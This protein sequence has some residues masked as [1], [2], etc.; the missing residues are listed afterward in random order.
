MVSIWEHLIE[1]ERGRAET[2]TLLRRGMDERQRQIGVSTGS[3]PTDSK[4]AEE[5]ILLRSQSHSMLQGKGNVWYS[6]VKRNVVSVPHD[7]DHPKYAVQRIPGPEIP[8]P[9]LKESV[10]QISKQPPL[11]GASQGIPSN[12]LKATE[13]NLVQYMVRDSYVKLINSDLPLEHFLSADDKKKFEYLESFLRHDPSYKIIKPA[14]L[15]RQD[16]SKFEMDDN[17][18]VAKLRQ[19]VEDVEN[20]LSNLID[21]SKRYESEQIQK[22][23]PSYE[24]LVKSPPEA[25]RK[26]RKSPER[27]SNKSP[28]INPD[29]QPKKRKLDPLWSYNNQVGHQ[30]SGAVE[31]TPEQKPLRESRCDQVIIIGAHEDEEFSDNDEKHVRNRKQMEDFYMSGE[32]PPAVL[33][34]SESLLAGQ[35]SM[36]DEWD[37]FPGTE[38][39]SPDI[40]LSTEEQQVAAKIAEILSA[41][42]DSE[43]FSQHHYEPSEAS[44]FSVPDW[45]SEVTSFTSADNVDIMPD[46]CQLLDMST[47]MKATSDLPV[48]VTEQPTGFVVEKLVDLLGSEKAI[49]KK[50]PDSSVGVVDIHEPK[51]IFPEPPLIEEMDTLERGYDVGEDEEFPPP[52]PPE[53]SVS[54]SS[55]AIETTDRSLEQRYLILSEHDISLTDT[56][57]ESNLQN[58]AE[59]NPSNFVSLLSAVPLEEPVFTTIPQDIPGSA[60]E[61]VEGAQKLSPTIV[62]SVLDETERN[63]QISPDA[64]SSAD[65]QVQ[66]AISESLLQELVMSKT[67]KNVTVFE[68][69]DSESQIAEPVPVHFQIMNKTDL[70][71]DKMQVCEAHDHS[72]KSPLTSSSF[73]KA[74]EM[75]EQMLDAKQGIEELQTLFAKDEYDTEVPKE[76]TCL[77]TVSVTTVKDEEYDAEVPKEGTCSPTVSVTTVKKPDF[78]NSDAEI[79]H[80]DG[81]LIVETCINDAHP[82]QGLKETEEKPMFREYIKEKEK[83]PVLETDSLT[84]S[85]ASDDTVEFWKMASHNVEK[86]IAVIEGAVERLTES[87]KELQLDDSNEF[88]LSDKPVSKD[89]EKF[90]EKPWEGA[91][92]KSDKPLSGIE[93][94]TTTENVKV[95]KAS[96]ESDTFCSSDGVKQPTGTHYNLPQE[97]AVETEASVE[98]QDGAKELL[99]KIREV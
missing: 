42:D 17:E 43:T 48:V 25:I 84:M 52:P 89:L 73:I 65:S 64:E 85:P 60:S 28:D 58:N 11:P 24:R 88:Q 75:S 86:L 90:V 44:S 13:G 26:L 99:S 95:K 47:L 51:G 32:K 34:N 35:G 36:T 74:D 30:T 18:T 21:K 66:N 2:Q 62:K 45:A 37:Q 31:Q 57:T 61:I 78:E 5:P 40:T 22:E 33:L 19:S 91:N 3:L 71:A 98:Q 41:Q 29:F 82:V 23:P 15:P 76:G 46:S 7:M 6:P 97:N 77:P 56:K 80:I 20:F 59:L 68:P 49:L 70:V 94:G 72:Q 63:L 16:L 79:E 8:L 92:I 87:L 55:F 50:V 27:G 10:P 9:G 93:D 54:D 39:L 83:L 67:D 38:Y 1:V 53:D 14:T 69:T 4:G 12:D 81:N 96:Q